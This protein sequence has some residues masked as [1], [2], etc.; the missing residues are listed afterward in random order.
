MKLGD[1]EVAVRAFVPVLTALLLIAPSTARAQLVRG[2]PE[3]FS[4]DA[5]VKTAK[6]SATAAITIQVQR[7]TP[8]FDRK[9]V[10]TGLKAAGYNGF[11]TA[12][13]KAP[14]VGYVEIGDQKYVIRYARERT[15][16]KGR[17]IV[18]V[19]EKPV[20]FIGGGATDPKARDVYQVAVIQLEVDENGSGSGTL[21]AAARV[22][23]GGETGVQLDDYGEEP[24]KLV[25][26]KRQGS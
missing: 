7:Y 19:T 6:A 21:A 2:A 17:D 8:D 26:V 14:N 18:L 12:L 4:A 3:T 1:E 11:L 20:F 25:S 15:S 10:E 9:S 23:P 13:R 22:R 24:I 5:H 16:P